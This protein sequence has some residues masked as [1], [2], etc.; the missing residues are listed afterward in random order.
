MSDTYTLASRP[1]AVLV[2]NVPLLTSSSVTVLSLVQTYLNARGIDKSSVRGFYIAGTYL[3]ATNK[4][5]DRDE[6]LIMHEALDNTDR[7]KEIVT[8]GFEWPARFTDIERTFIQCGDG[9][10]DQ[11]ALFVFLVND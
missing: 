5:I 3:D 10:T 7:N 9:V 2:T 1:V 6:M 4:V 8:K 11:N